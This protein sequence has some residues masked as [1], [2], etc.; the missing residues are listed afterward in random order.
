MEMEECRMDIVHKR[1]RHRELLGH[2]AALTQTKERIAALA[3]KVD[4]I[5]AIWR[6][7][8]RSPSPSASFL[9]VAY[10]DSDLRWGLLAQVRHATAA[11]AAC[12]RGRPGHAGHQGEYRALTTY[13]ARI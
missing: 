3:E 6:V 8:S 12:A 4:T 11:R 10:Y 5:T 9:F 1:D 2:E 7:V 13:G